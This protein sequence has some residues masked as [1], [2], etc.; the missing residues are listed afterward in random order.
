MVTISLH[1][2]KFHGFHGCYEE[3]KITGN[4]FEVNMDVSFNESISVITSLHESIN[5]V[6][7]F[8]MVKSRMKQASLLL[9]TI[10]ME[11]AEEIKKRF[12]QVTEVDIAVKKSNPPIFNFQGSTSVRFRKQY[13]T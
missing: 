7:L 5:Y 9:E 3:E 10:A 13:H 8:E 2:L 6:S 12:P 11:L 1:H 4:E